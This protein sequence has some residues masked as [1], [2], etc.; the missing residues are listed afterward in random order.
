M[1]ITF[2]GCVATPRIT[3]SGT[4]GSQY[5]FAVENAR[6][7]NKLV[8]IRRIMSLNDPTIAVATVK[9]KLVGYRSS[10]PLT[11][12][13]GVVLL[14]KGTF[15][16]TQTSD[17][18]V[19][20]WCANSLDAYLPGGVGIGVTSPVR[21]WSNAGSRVHTVIE[22][23]AAEDSSLLPVLIHDYPFYL[24]PGESYIV[25]VE[26]A[27]VTSD[28]VA[29]Y[30]LI[31]CVWFE[32]TLVNYFTISGTVTFNSTPVVGA[33]VVVLAADD[34]ALTNAYIQSIVTTTAGGAWTC[35]IPTGKIGYAYAQNDVTGTFYT[36]PAAPFLS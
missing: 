18:F 11:I 15:D 17:P 7:S 22:Q 27:A 31:N 34:T 32:E 5:L 2:T 29:N 6:G 20:V 25:I 16:S 23:I 8:S 30:W 28:P 4:T 13:T 24:A 1:A 14:G 10:Q 35:N 33:E 19:K 3:G 26:S 9:P 12:G 36:A 21:C